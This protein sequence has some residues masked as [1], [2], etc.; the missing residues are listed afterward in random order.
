MAYVDFPQDQ[1]GQKDRKR[2]WL[3][4]DGLALI[5]G[6]RMQGIPIE[7]I[8]AY[9]VGVGTTTWWRWQKESPD[10]LNTLKVS[11]QNT[12]NMVVASLLKKAL[13]YDYDEVTQELVEGKMRVTKVVN[14]HVTPDVKACLAWLYSRQATLWRSSQEPIDS[15]ADEVKTAQKILVAIKEVADG[16]PNPA[17]PQA[18]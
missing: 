5:Q 14:R 11:K 10:L 15:T 1:R 8:G 13:G 7:E 6:W 12:D 17:E 4:P 18:D 9:Y 16:Q 3:S 2:F